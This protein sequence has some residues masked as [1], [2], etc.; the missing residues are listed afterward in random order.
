MAK[1]LLIAMILMSLLIVVIMSGCSHS[2]IVKDCNK[3]DG[4][5][6]FSVCKNLKPWE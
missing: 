6:G 5:S 2:M 3:V 4:D 1:G